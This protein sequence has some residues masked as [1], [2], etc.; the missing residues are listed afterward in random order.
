MATV[1]ASTAALAADLSRQASYGSSLGMLSSIM[2]I[3]HASGPI[4]AGFFVNTWGYQINFPLIGIIMAAPILIFP[5]LVRVPQ[6]VSPEGIK[7]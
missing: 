1:T 4:V 5:L 7:E 6:R 3:G 2:D